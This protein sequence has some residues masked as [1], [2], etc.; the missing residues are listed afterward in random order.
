LLAELEDGD[1]KAQLTVGHAL[2][3]I[4]ADAIKPLLAEYAASEDTSR[5]TFILYALGKIKSPA[6][7]Q[8]LPLALAAVNAPDHELR[9]TATRAV[10]KFSESMRPADLS[11]ETVKEMFAKLKVNLGDVSPGIRAKAAR[12]LGKLAKFGLL[13]E[14]ERADLKAAFQRLLGQD[15]NYEWDRAYIV[16]REAEEALQYLG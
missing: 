1:M 6:I 7:I 4:G 3:R 14:P 10:G 13:K 8:A 11:E 9:D 16:R 2:G 12:S 15:E 5:H